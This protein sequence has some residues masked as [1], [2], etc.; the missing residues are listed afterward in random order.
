MGV[1][2]LE[3]TDEGADLAYEEAKDSDDDTPDVP[4]AWDTG[5]L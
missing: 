1:W 3:I 4:P 5:E 2:N